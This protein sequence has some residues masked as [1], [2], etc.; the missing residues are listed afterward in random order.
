MLRAISE[1]SRIKQPISPVGYKYIIDDVPSNIYP[2]AGN[3]E[4]Y[5]VV[6]IDMAQP[7]E[8][9]EPVEINHED[10]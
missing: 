4:G 3:I 10:R 8:E 2:L 9:K 1:Y 6:Q 7:P 5:S